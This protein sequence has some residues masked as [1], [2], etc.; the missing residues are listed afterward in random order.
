M[1]D[2]T[3]WLYGSVARGDYDPESSDLDVL[4][5]SDSECTPDIV[6]RLTS[7]LPCSEHLSL[8]RYGWSE[9]RAM[10]RYGSLFLW[11]LR[12]EGRPLMDGPGTNAFRGLLEQLPVY[13]ES[14][15]DVNGF[16]LALQDCANSLRDGGDSFFELAIIATVL[17]HASILACSVHGIPAYARGRTLEIALRQ[18]DMQEHLEEAFALYHFR[19]GLARGLPAVIPPSYELAAKWLEIA[20]SFVNSLE[21]DIG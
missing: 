8:V 21:V 6:P 14:A 13:S 9:L 4:L 5:V 17:R 15:R 3:I 16:R 18:Y 1:N 20:N 10:A 7:G 11:H 19:L 2:W 12:T